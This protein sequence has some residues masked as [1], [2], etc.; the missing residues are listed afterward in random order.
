MAGV[1][2]TPSSA[3]GLRLS[4]RG[5]AV[6][7]SRRLD[8]SSR[9]Q[10]GCLRKSIGTSFC[11]ER[12]CADTTFFVFAWQLR[13]PDN[14]KWGHFVALAEGVVA[15]KFLNEAFGNRAGCAEGKCAAIIGIEND[16]FSADS[17]PDSP[18][19]FIRFI[20]SEFG[21]MCVFKN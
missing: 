13:F 11:N 21:G 16:R 6:R 8:G 2:M 18:G 3:N 4:A 19:G 9:F 5:V 7:T 17:V 14:A 12:F 20:R 15:E 10:I 1:S